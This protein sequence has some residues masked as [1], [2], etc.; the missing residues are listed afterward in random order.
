MKILGPIT[1]KVGLNSLTLV[2]HTEAKAKHAVLP[3]ERFC[4]NGIKH[5]DKDGVGDR[6]RQ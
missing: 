5:K 3:T 2:G 4:V 6:Q 1:W